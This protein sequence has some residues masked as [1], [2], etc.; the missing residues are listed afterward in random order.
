MSTKLPEVADLEESGELG[1]QQTRERDAEKKQIGADYVDQRHQAAEKYLQ[2]GDLVLL[3][4]RKKNELSLYYEK[5][6]YQV[7]ARYGDQVQLMSPQGV[8]YKRNIRNVKRFVTPNIEPE[9][10][11][12]AGAVVVPGEQTSGQEITP[13]L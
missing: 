11:N 6:P 13:S 12:P 1:Y 9:E 7:I 3:E 8:E 4:K 10:T 2:E 5:E